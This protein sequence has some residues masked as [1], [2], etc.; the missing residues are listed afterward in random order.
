MSITNLHTATRMPAAL[1]VDRRACTTHEGV[2]GVCEA[3]PT[4]TLRAQRS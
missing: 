4:K 2:A 1:V 3:A